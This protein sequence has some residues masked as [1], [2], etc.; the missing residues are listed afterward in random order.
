ME[1][2]RDGFLFLKSEPRPRHHSYI[3]LKK[4]SLIRSAW[5]SLRKAINLMQNTMAEIN[6]VQS[7]KTLYAL[8]NIFNILSNTTTSTS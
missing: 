5:C 8:L 2:K 3:R 7:K 6:H 4:T 1:G